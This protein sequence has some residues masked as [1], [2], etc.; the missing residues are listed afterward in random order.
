MSHDVGQIRG[1]SFTNIVENFTKKLKRYAHTLYLIKD[2]TIHFRNLTFSRIPNKPD[3]EN[4]IYTSLTPGCT[5]PLKNH[6]LRPDLG[7]TGLA[8]GS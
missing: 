4:K 8:V 2:L 5:S 1:E 3:W 7:F 6:L